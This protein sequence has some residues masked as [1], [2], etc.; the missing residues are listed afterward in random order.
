MYC[1][2]NSMAITPACIMSMDCP[3]ADEVDQV[4]AAGRIGDEL[5][6]LIDQTLAAECQSCRVI[7][8]HATPHSAAA[9]VRH[10]QHCVP[11][12]VKETERRC[13]NALSISIAVTSNWVK[14]CCRL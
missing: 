9:W 2:Q 6:L 10:H 8:Q 5:T 3:S 1:W 4:K 13:F 7:L 11:V 12:L 14:L